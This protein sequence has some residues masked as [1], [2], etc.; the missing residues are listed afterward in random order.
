VLPALDFPGADSGVTFL[1]VSP[2]FGITWDVAGNGRTVAKAAANRYYGQYV[3]T[4]TILN[5]V[6]ASFVQFPW[7][8]GNGD[9]TVQRAELD[10]TRRLAFSANY[11]PAN[12][13]NV[14]SS[15]HVDPSLDNDIV[16][17]FIAGVDHELM[18]DFA[19]GVA[20]IH[21]RIGNFAIN[22][23]DGL[24]ADQFQRVPFTAACGNASCEQPGYTTAYYQLPAPIAGTRTRT[25]QDFTRVFHGLEITARK[26]MSRDWMMNG[27]LT[28]NSAVYTST[29]DS[30]ADTI[31]PDLFGVAALPSDQTNRE[32]IDS[33]QT[34]IN[35]TRWVA[36]L[37]GLYQLPWG[38]NLAG[39]LNARDGFPF[40]PNLLSPARAGSLGTIRVMVEPYATHRYEAL[41]LLDLKAEKRFTLGRT[42]L[43][44]S[45]DVFNV[46]N[47]NTV[48]NRVTT[49]NSA[50]ANRVVEV[51][52]PRVVRLGMRLAF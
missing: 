4:S 9:R 6:G 32:F 49:Q 16:T 25:T 50:T 37:S 44:G 45:L 29:A 38:V 12:P 46:T 2:R 42:T 48:L 51:T 15:N 21:R 18:A 7:S 31:N 10:L 27:S 24:S 1:D 33:Q 23:P 13:A 28:L 35:G 3:D 41:V 11:N 34:L 14:L 36:K 43:T 20:Y 17:E 19:L 30:Y 26:R 39:T 40:I 22:V 47:S 8:D 52:G 5:P